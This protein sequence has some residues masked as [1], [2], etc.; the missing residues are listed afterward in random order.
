MYLES[1]LKVTIGNTVIGGTDLLICIPLV[2]TDKARLRKETQN[3]MRNH[4][5]L[6]EWRVDAFN[7]A[8]DRNTCLDTLATLREGIGDIPLIFTCRSY[9]EGGLANISADKREELILAAIQSGYVDVI[10][11]EL[12]NDEVFIHNIQKAVKHSSLA[13]ILSYHNFK[14]TPEP[15]FIIDTL[16]QARDMG[17]DIAKVAVMP[18][19]FEDVLALMGAAIKARKDGL[20]IPMIAISMGTLGSLSR[21]AAKRFGADITFASSDTPSAPGQTKIRLLQQAINTLYHS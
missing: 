13:M 14:S 19:D 18:Q 20:K 8:I 2:A 9:A 1:D 6:L 10:D 17:A 16:F 3:A 4:P 12:S 5:D 11:I 7:S 15:V 21:L